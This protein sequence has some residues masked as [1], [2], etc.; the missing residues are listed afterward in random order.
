MDDEAEFKVGDIVI[1][2]GLI[3]PYDRSPWC[4]IVLSIEKDGWIFSTIYNNEPQDRV[5]IL[6]LDSGLTE[7]LPDSVL[8]LHYRAEENIED[9][10]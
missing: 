9:E 10:S 2:K 8:A 7:E 3:V 5:I 6:W 4:G 1:E